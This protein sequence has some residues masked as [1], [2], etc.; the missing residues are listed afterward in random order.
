MVERRQS[1]CQWI[2]HRCLSARQVCACTVRVCI[3]LVASLV[4]LRS[5]KDNSFRSTL[6]I[7]SH[8]RFHIAVGTA[9]HVVRP[10]YRL[11]SVLRR[12]KER[13]AKDWNATLIIY[14]NRCQTWLLKTSRVPIANSI[15][16]SP[17]L[18]FRLGRLDGKSDMYGAPTQG[19]KGFAGAKLNKKRSFVS[20]ILG[21]VD[22]GATQENLSITLMRLKVHTKGVLRGITQEMPPSDILTFFSYLTADGNYFPKGFFFEEEAKRLSFDDLGA[23]RKLAVDVEPPDNL[24]HTL[25]ALHHGNILQ[26]ELEE[27]DAKR[28][29]EGFFEGRRSKWFVSDLS[30]DGKGDKTGVSGAVTRPTDLRA[31]VLHGSDQ[32]QGKLQPVYRHD[33]SSR[34]FDTNLVEMVLTNYLMVRVLIPWILLYPQES[35]LVPSSGVKPSLLAHNCQVLASVVYL[36]MR[37]LRPELTPPNADTKQAAALE[38]SERARKKFEEDEKAARG[39]TEEGKQSGSENGVGESEDEGSGEE[40][41]RRRA[42]GK[43]VNKKSDPEGNSVDRNAPSKADDAMVPAK[44]DESRARDG[45]A[46]KRNK[47]GLRT[48]RANARVRTQPHPRTVQQIMQHKRYVSLSDKQLV[49]GLLPDAYFMPVAEQLRPWVLELAAEFDLWMQNVVGIVMNRVENGVNAIR[50]ERAQKEHIGEQDT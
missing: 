14:F 40:T 42:I 12:S 46:D 49:Q 47:K 22:R 45:R 6:K 19:V 48:R 35:G 5:E 7:R 3:T 4:E 21:A 16:K 13:D 30:Q 36:V 18:T 11:A 15:L 31:A 17:K 33:A 24:D 29:H 43:K 25:Y 37:V 20:S 41:T 50:Q 44:S 8:R 26:E 23:V 1:S 32:L 38:E 10:M 34:W 28:Q 27:A 39:E 9:H 2:Q